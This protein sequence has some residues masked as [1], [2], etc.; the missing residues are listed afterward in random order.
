MIDTSILDKI[1]KDTLAAMETGKQQIFN[2]AE[3]TQNECN[4]L[5][6]ELK[7]VIE[8]LKETITLVDDIEINEKRARVHLMKVSRDFKR[9]SEEDIKNAYDKAQKLQIQ[10]HDMR[11]QEQMLYYRRNHLEINLRNLKNTL[12]KVERTLSHLSTAINYLN[13]SLCQVSLKIDEL[14]QIHDLG[15]NII[16]AQEEERKRIAR[17]IHDGLAQMMANIVMR[18]E[19]CLKLL[20]INPIQLREELNDLRELV[21]QSLQDVRKIIFNLRP[22]VLDD[23]GLVAALK[24]YVA[25]FEDQYNTRAAFAFFGEDRRLPISI[26]VT[27]FRIVQECLNNICKHAE[28]RNVLVKMEILPQKISLSIKDDGKGF[29]PPEVKSN[30]RLDGYGLISIRERMQLIN[31]NLQISSVPGNGTTVYISVPLTN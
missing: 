28:A 12:Y 27:L 29:N 17:E 9:Y 25:D 7:Q 10:L 14:Q 5:E 20:E 18:A 11:H 8:E 3:T 30:N 19:F 31:G 26:E 6:Q 15:V 2:I 13:S 21:R 4:R 1:I 23:L 24:R 22:M 16:K